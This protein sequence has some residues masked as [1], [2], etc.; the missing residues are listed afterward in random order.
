MVDF[1]CDFDRSWTATP[2]GDFKLV[3]GL[4]NA[5]QAVY[6]RLKTRLGELTALGHSTYGNDAINVPGTTNRAVAENKVIIYTKNCLLQEPR[7]ETIE[8]IKVIWQERALIIDATVTLIGEDKPTNL[9]FKYLED[10]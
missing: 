1:G 4:S 5:E 2:Q 9:I 3:T 8:D 6:N 7:V 10:Y